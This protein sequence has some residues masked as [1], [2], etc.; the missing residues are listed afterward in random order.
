MSAVYTTSMVMPEI[1]ILILYRTYYIAFINLHVVNIIQQF[2]IGRTDLLAQFNAPRRFIAH[3]IF[4][5]NLA[6]EQFHLD[7][8]SFLFCQAHY[9]LEAF[10]TIVHTG[11]V[12]HSTA[13]AAEADQV[14]IAGFG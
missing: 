2:E 6:V 8:Y 9:L 11:L 12:I 10:S 5:I 4:V 13:V 7:N 14:L 1:S 3:I